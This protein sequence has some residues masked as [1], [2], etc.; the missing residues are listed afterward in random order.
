M[1]QNDDPI[2]QKM[3]SFIDQWRQSNLTQKLFCEQ[4]TIQYSVFHYWYKR[5]RTQ[6]PNH[7]GSQKFIKL[8]ISPSIGS[9]YA[10]LVLSDGKRLLFHQPVTSDYLKTLIG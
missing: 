4:N 3:F 7:E 9:V 5:Y 6:N 10:E 2:R 1:M 8:A